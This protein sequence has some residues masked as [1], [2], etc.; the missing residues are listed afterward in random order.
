M[1]ELKD[2]CR[3]NDLQGYS[4]LRKSELVD[5]IAEALPGDYQI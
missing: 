2:L 3:E 4:K 5:F 1:A